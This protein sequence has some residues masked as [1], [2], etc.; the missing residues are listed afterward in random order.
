MARPTSRIGLFD[1]GISAFAA[2]AVGFAAAAMPE[3]RLFSL[4]QMTGLPDILAAAN[5][6]LGLKAR[7]GVAALLSAGAFAGVFLLMRLLDRLPARRTAEDFDEQAQAVNLPIRLRRADAH[8]DNPARRPLIAGRELGEPFDELLLD[9]P[10][11]AV[12]GP[13]TTPRGPLPSFLVPDDEPLIPASGADEPLVPAEREAETVEFVELA[14]PL[15]PSV[16]RA[17]PPAFRPVAYPAPEPVVP[18]VPPR[19]AVIVAPVETQQTAERPAAPAPREAPAA[20]ADESISDLMARLES[21]LRRRERPGAGPQ[22]APAADDTVADRL[23]S[24][25]T[26]LQR[27]ASRG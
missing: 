3:W 17:P 12:P 26:D 6:P 25:M 10:A 2:L 11:E 24:A 7:F 15:A 1:L 13:E 9:S 20:S 16:D 23:R 5:P 14:P 18:E 27:L 4:L 21:G 22:T 19:E 8:P